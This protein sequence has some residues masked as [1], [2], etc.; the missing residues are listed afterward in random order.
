MDIF[1]LKGKDPADEA[2]PEKTWV[3]VT[4]REVDA[5]KLVPGNFEVYEVEARTGD[6]GGMPGV[7]GWMGGTEAPTGGTTEES[8]IVKAPEVNLGDRFVSVGSAD[9]VW[10]VRRIVE[11]PGLPTHVELKCSGH[12]KRTVVIGKAVLLDRGHYRKMDIQSESNGT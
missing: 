4:E 11:C 3:V 9:L 7:I 6:L 1:L 12:R 5:R 2:N 10:V 8:V